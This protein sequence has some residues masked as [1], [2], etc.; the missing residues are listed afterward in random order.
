MAK[1]TF[2]TIYDEL[3]SVPPKKAFVTRIAFVT[4]KSESTVRMWLC[5]R[6]YPDE[7]TRTVIAKEL[8]VEASD[9][10]PEVTN[11]QI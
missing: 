1:K 4:H 5:G 11:K 3:S 6:Q 10:F 7:L 9:L 2:K 8:Q